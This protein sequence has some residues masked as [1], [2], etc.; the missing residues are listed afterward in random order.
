MKIMK[1]FSTEICLLRPK[2]DQL[3][4]QIQNFF[5]RINRYRL[6][7][8]LSRRDSNFLFSNLMYFYRKKF[9]MTYTKKITC[10]FELNFDY[11][12]ECSNYQSN[13]VK[14]SFKKCMFFEENYRAV[15]IFI[16]NLQ[17]QINESLLRWYFPKILITRQ[18]INKPIFENLVFCWLEKYE[19]YVFAICIIKSSC[20]WFV[21]CLKVA[22][23]K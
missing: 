7:F 1:I 10:C 23:E 15:D 2:T 17:L 12:N 9:S 13:H 14:V 8:T 22:K 11:S 19:N 20:K 5:Q 4:F 3:F 6:F 16:G 18:F 21:F